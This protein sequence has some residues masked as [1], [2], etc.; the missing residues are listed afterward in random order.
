[1]SDYMADITVEI[2]TRETFYIAADKMLREYP[3]EWAEAQSQGLTEPEWI[4]EALH[5]MGCDDIDWLS[6]ESERD[7]SDFTVTIR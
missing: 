1:M 4:K 2:E 5:E 3:D 6:H 7:T